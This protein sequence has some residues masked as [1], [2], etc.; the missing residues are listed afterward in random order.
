VTI[1]F[2]GCFNL[3]CNVL[4]CVC[5]GFVVCGCFDNR[6]GVLVMCVIVFCIVFTVFL[7][8]II[9]VYLFLFCLCYC[10]DYCH[11]VIAELQLIIIIIESL[12]PKT[13]CFCNSYVTVLYREKS[14]GL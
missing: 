2:G 7:Y 6:V 13:I 1:S 14:Q 11:R 8:C 5:V 4:F 10:K 12:R 3:F 9:C